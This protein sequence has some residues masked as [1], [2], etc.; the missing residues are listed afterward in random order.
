MQEGNFFDSIQAQPNAMDDLDSSDE[1]DADEVQPIPPRSPLS[2]H[3][4]VSSAYPGSPYGEAGRQRVISTASAPVPRSPISMKFGNHSTPH[5]SQGYGSGFGPMKQSLQPIG[6]VPPKSQFFS[7]RKSDHGHTPLDYYRYAQGAVGGVGGKAGIG[8]GAAIG[9]GIG[10]GM[11]IGMGSASGS[12]ASAIGSLGLGTSLS[13]GTTLAGRTS[14]STNASTSLSSSLGPGASAGGMSVEG[15]DEVDTRRRP[16]VASSTMTASSSKAQESMRKL[17][18]LLLQHMEAEKDTIKR[19]A[20]TLKANAGA[21]VAGGVG[22]GGP[23][24]AIHVSSPDK[25]DVELPAVSSSSSSSL[26][27]GERTPIP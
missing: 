2:Q 22:R 19:I 27:E 17:D 16:S 9:A 8:I 23:A 26:G 11:G 6:N 4:H 12:V 7:E 18:G 15:L 5:V 1:S 14:T 25:E 20:T 13:G 3:S 24:P 10:V 21:G